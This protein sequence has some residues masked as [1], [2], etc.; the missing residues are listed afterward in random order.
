[1]FK[2]NPLS[3]PV[4]GQ[5]WGGM[6]SLA[7]LLCL[8]MDHTEGLS[9]LQSSPMATSKVSDLGPLN[10][11]HCPVLCPSSLKVL[12][13]KTL[14]DKAPVCQSPRHGSNGEWVT[15]L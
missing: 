14:L 12:F 11:S 15:V 5:W 7:W 4:T 10:F 3:Y 6:V 1:M 2:A 9:Q 8:K 13:S